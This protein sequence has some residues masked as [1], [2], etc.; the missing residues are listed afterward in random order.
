MI[1]LQRDGI[2]TNDLLIKSQRN[3][4]MSVDADV[5]CTTA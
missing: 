1:C 2:R 4:P 3:S 5:C